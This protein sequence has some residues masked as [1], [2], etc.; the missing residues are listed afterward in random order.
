MRYLILFLLLITSALQAQEPLDSTLVDRFT[1]E[2]DSYLSGQDFVYE[3]KY[4]TINYDQDEEY[5]KQALF[6]LEQAILETWQ[7]G[8]TISPHQARKLQLAVNYYS[9]VVETY[10]NADYTYYLGIPDN[11]TELYRMGFKEVDISFA[12]FIKFEVDKW[13]EDGGNN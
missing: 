8:G 2:D 12:T 4:D 13:L 6:D 3:W 7:S 11:K 5:F 1:F 9:F 10:E